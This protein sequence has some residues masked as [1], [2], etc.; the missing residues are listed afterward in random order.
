MQKACKVLQGVWV[1]AKQILNE[2]MAYEIIRCSRV[3]VLVV[4]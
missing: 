1:S 2:R 4:G 3:R